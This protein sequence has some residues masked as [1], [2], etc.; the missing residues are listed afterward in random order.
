MVV[1]TKTVPA[2]EGVSTGVQVS[3]VIHSK[4]AFAAPSDDVARAIVLTEAAKIAKIDD[5]LQPVE[6]KLRAW[7]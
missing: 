7:A 1:R 3:E 6:V 4:C 2:G 5:E